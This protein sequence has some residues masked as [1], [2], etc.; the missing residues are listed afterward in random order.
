MKKFYI[1]ILTFM[2]ISSTYAQSDLNPFLETN[3]TPPKAYL[4]FSTGI[5]NMIGII[6]PQLDVVINKNLTIGAGI[7]L[8]SWG[9]KWA[10]N[11]QFYPQG[12][13]KFYVKGGYSQNSGLEDFEP[14]MELSNGN[15]DY[16]LMDLK[17]VGNVFFT[18]GYAWKIGKRNKFYLEGGYALPLI[19]EDYYELYD[20]SVKLS[21]TSEQ[22]MQ[23]LRP[24]GLVIALGLNFAL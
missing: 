5:N 18:A 4:G 20:D 8:S 10:I 22:L 16:V 6:G 7:G 14:E 1:T 19:T 2:L 21:S 13:N 17:P 11:M 9:T 15:T 23:L 24:G 12:W 3:F